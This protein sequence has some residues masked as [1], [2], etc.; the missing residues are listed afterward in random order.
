MSVL[1]LA[2]RQLAGVSLCLVLASLGGCL[3]PVAAPSLAP[4]PAE[5]Q[6]IDLP[7]E[8]SEPQSAA[9]PDL[10]RRIAPLLAAA[11]AGARAFDEQRRATDSA[12]ARAAGTAAE[13]EAWTV[14]QQALSA[15]D[16]ARAPVQDATA[17]IE[18]L[19][20]QP[21]NAASGNRAAIDAA[22]TRIEAI[23][24]AQAEAMAA[25]SARLH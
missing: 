23:G 21:A 6:P 19:R 13:G 10:V 17:A 20:L 4:R 11:D 9:D 5:R 12:I 18:E 14:A 25:L 1:P 3:A 15:L 7:A 24:Q 22:A 2:G 8:T 16:A